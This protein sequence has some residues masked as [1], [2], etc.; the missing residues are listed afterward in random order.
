M[1]QSRKYLI[2]SLIVLIALLVGFLPGCSNEKTPQYTIVKIIPCQPTTDSS[3][4]EIRYISPKPPFMVI[5]YEAISPHI[6]FN[7]I[8][9]KAVDQNGYIFEFSE[10][11][12]M[13][14][15]DIPR[16]QI[17][18]MIGKKHK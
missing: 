13:V 8:K 3:K 10:P 14:H 2:V 4:I 17:G 11:F 9:Y 18:D 1:L 15:N 5:S 12:N 6:G 16:L 7:I